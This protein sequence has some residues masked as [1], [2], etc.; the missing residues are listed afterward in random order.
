MSLISPESELPAGSLEGGSG[1][2]LILLHG[3]LGTPLMWRTT[4]PLLAASHRVIAL[5]ALG[6]LGGRPCE[7]R[8]CRIAHV[9]DDAERSLDALGVARAHLAGNSMGGWMALELA[10][11]GR[12]LSVCA[13]SPAGMWDGTLHG[14][15]RGRLRSTVALTRWTRPLLPWFA[16]AGAIRR[17]GLRDNAV[18]GERASQADL[19]ALADAVLGC[20]VAEDLLDTPEQLAPLEVSCPVDI[21]WSGAD[22]IFPPQPFQEIARQRVPCAR[23]LTLPGVGH[24]PMIDDPELVARTILQTVAR[25]R[26]SEGNRPDAR[27]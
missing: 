3:V 2:P 12:A 20:T 23:H 26:A 19:V 25:A 21:A 5:P 6:H 16:N 11:R 9:V 24:V 14:E 1:E 10:R 7:H 17:F 18:H 13:L 27:P 15:G 8:P 22:R 4:L